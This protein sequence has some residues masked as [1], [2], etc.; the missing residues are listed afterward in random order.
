MWLQVV[1]QAAAAGARRH[2]DAVK[3]EVATAKQEAAAAKKAAAAAR[4]ES[5]AAQQG[6]S[7][8]R[9]EAAAAR[10]DAAA[11]RHEAAAARMASEAAARDAAAATA[12]ERVR[13]ALCSVWYPLCW[14]Y[15]VTALPT[16]FHGVFAL[17]VQCA[18][19]RPPRHSGMLSSE[20]SRG[21]RQPPATRPSA[22]R[23]LQAPKRQALRCTAILR[24]GAVPSPR[25]IITGAFA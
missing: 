21:Q 24:R 13:A 20:T 12:A 8:A 5:T 9:R 23:R 22:W 6:A 17:R 4:Q 7:A 11:A 14:A 1:Q 25:Y 15:E 16:V 10:A 3:Q 19:Y 18:Q 2:I